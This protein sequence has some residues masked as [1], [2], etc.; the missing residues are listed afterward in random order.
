MCMKEY[1]LA[2]L[3]AQAQRKATTSTKYVMKRKV[4]PKFYLGPIERK[5]AEQDIITI[6][7]ERRLNKCQQPAIRNVNTLLCWWSKTES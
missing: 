2:P 5:C 3:Y 1:T 4:P 6:E 7:K